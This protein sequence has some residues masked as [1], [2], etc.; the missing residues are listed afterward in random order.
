MWGCLIRRC[1]SNSVVFAVVDLARQT[2]A[3]HDR[4]SANSE[5]RQRNY[6]SIVIEDTSH[7]SGAAVFSDMSSHKKLLFFP[8]LKS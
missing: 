1:D 6:N 3:G 5:H 7:I 8:G 2:L 4:H